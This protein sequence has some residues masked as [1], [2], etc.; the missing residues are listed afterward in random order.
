MLVLRWWPGWPVSVWHY[1][2]VPARH[3]PRADVPC[4][5]CQPGEETSQHH[6]GL[7]SR[8]QDPHWP[9]YRFYSKEHCYDKGP[10][11]GSSLEICFMIGVWIW[12]ILDPVSKLPQNASWR[13]NFEK[14]F[15]HDDEGML[16]WSWHWKTWETHLQNVRLKQGKERGGLAGVEC[17]KNQ[18][19]E[20]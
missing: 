12:I 7:C 2:S 6:H 4:E 10:S 17:N 18:S 20:L 15:S 16:P 1:L 19:K 3:Q 11:W 13:P 9:R 14:I 8:H 5:D